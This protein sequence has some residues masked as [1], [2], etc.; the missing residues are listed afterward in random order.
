[1]MCLWVLSRRVKG[2]IHPICGCGTNFV[3]NIQY[4]LISE[5]SRL[6][7]KFMLSFSDICSMLFLDKGYYTSAVHSEDL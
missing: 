3:V 1:M 2:S 5:T 6:F 7:Y 4:G